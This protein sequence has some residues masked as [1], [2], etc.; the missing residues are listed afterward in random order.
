VSGGPGASSLFP[1]GQEQQNH[2]PH[3][4]VYADAAS[5]P[6][7][8]GN[9]LVAGK[10]EN[11]KVGHLAFSTADG[12]TYQC[13]AV[14]T[15][16]GGDATW[17]PTAASASVPDR[18]DHS[19]NGGACD[20]FTSPQPILR[21]NTTVNAVG[22]F[23]GG[24]TG[25]KAIL[26]HWLSAPLPLGALLSVVLDYERLTPEVLAGQRLPSLLFVVELDPVGA[27]GF[28]S[29]LTCGDETNPLNLGTY[30][31]PA[32][33]V[34]RISWT[35]GANF[36]QVVGDKGVGGAGFSPPSPTAGP[37]PI[38][39]SEGPSPGPAPPPPGT[40]WTVRDYSIADLLVAYP[41]AQI[42][43][44][45]SGD[46]GLP[47]LTQTA[48]AMI[49]LGDSGTVLQNAVRVVSWKINGSAV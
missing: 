48:G 23:N 9:V 25:N 27:M 45:A 20:Q 6:N 14:G 17:T 32:P 38:P 47:K 33:G 3:W 1:A 13:S 29:I 31:T 8:A 39:T 28:Y 36:I 44:A 5:L 35:P 22:G 12:A 19:V 43:N 37:D 21:T 30:S 15:V 24:G 2:Q 46:G 10:F 40:S 7:A 41:N 11:L 34:R 16:G 4:G 49:A 18:R 26:G 42:V